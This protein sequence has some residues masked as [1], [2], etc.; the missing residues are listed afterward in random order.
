MIW[1]DDFESTELDTGK[2]TRISPNKA[3]W[4]IHMTTDPQC[5]KIANEKLHLKGIVN[6]DTL[7]D[8][9]PFLIGGVYIKGKF[10]FQYGKIEIHARLEYACGAWPSMR[11]LA[12]QK[13]IRRLSYEWRN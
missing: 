4:G 11:M 10:A 13:K 3:D 2:C 8:P 7:L 6:P 5:Y 12:E 1:Q 9:R